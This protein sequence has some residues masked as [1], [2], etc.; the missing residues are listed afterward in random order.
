[1]GKCHT[2]LLSS[3]R[4]LRKSSV[5]S[6]GDLEQ[7]CLNACTLLCPQGEESASQVY[8][9]GQCVH[10]PASNC[11]HC[12]GRGSMLHSLPYSLPGLFIILNFVGW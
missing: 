5:V 2:R 11:C 4:C 9:M 10:F 7:S 3:L 8:S 6:E 1:M 12:Q